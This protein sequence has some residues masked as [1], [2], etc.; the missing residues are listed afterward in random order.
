MHECPL[1][2]LLTSEGP[3]LHPQ[4]LPWDHF[5]KASPVKITVAQLRLHGMTINPAF[6]LS[7]ITF[8]H[9]LHTTD[10]PATLF[11]IP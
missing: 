8:P 4:I 10:Q 11:F 1:T 6:F 9:T 5:L 3:K 2:D 7:P